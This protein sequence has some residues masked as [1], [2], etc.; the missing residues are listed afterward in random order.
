MTLEE[1]IMCDT[2]KYVFLFF[3]YKQPTR[4]K[5]VFMQNQSATCGRT[6][7]SFLNPVWLV[8][9]KKKKKCTVWH[10]FNILGTFYLHCGKNRPQKCKQP[11]DRLQE[12]EEGKKKSELGN[13]LNFSPQ[14]RQLAAAKSTRIWSHFS[15][16][17]VLSSPHCLRIKRALGGCGGGSWHGLNQ[18]NSPPKSLREIFLCR[19]PPGPALQRVTRREALIYL[20]QADRL[21]I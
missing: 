6:C 8:A 17:T 11:S 9:L 2:H 1:C 16:L 10:Y 7:W 4:S 18:H 14:R 12:E 3:G 15:P 5:T 13:N 21:V 19:R 20:K